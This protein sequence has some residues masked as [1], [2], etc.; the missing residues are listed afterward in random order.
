MSN[1]E[2]TEDL[3]YKMYKLSII[4]MAQD[5]LSVGVELHPE[6]VEDLRSI[7]ISPENFVRDFQE[8]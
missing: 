6:T 7:G 3:L 5:E 2:D 8:Q 4:E 1:T